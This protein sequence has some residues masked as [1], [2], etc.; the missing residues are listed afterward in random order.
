ML[1]RKQNPC[2]NI[3]KHFHLHTVNAICVGASGL[4]EA[5]PTSLVNAHNDYREC[6]QQPRRVSSLVFVPT[7]SSL[8]HISSKPHGNQ[9]REYPVTLPGFEVE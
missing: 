7:S 5:V 3:R 4:Q 2:K 6:G 1:V 8:S 9:L